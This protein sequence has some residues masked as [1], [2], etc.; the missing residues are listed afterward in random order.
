MLIF[1]LHINYMLSKTFQWKLLSF[2]GFSVGHHNLVYPPGI[3][4][5]P[6][7]NPRTI[8]NGTSTAR[9]NDTD[10]YLQPV[11]FT[12]QGTT[13]ISLEKN[14]HNECHFSKCFKTQIPPVYYWMVSFGDAHRM[15]TDVLFLTQGIHQFP[16]SFS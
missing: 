13:I 8:S 7:K 10:Y 9:N 1:T 11:L 16:I 6:N 2:S 4:W 14:E 3:I 12:N 15:H 5:D